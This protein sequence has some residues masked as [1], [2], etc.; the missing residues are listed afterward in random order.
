MW[1]A[2]FGAFIQEKITFWPKRLERVF[3]HT[4]AHIFSQVLSKQH[5]EL[6][7]K[8]ENYSFS[9]WIGNFLQ[10]L[11]ISNIE[12]TWNL[13]LSEKFYGSISM[14]HKICNGHLN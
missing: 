4:D 5:K 6:S 11:N 9:F 14:W 10:N 7:C 12:F 3:K 13:N 2:G 8:K 1:P